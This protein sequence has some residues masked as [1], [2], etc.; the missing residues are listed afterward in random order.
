MAAVDH[1]LKIDGIPGES[2][3]SKHKGEIDIETWEFSEANSGSFALGGGGGAGKVKMDDFTFSKK[4]D[5]AGPKLFQA[6]ASGEHIKGAV[7]T[8]RKAGKD[9]Q[10]YLKIT[11]AD[12]LISN[13]KIIAST[14][15]GEIVPKEVFKLNFSSMK[16]EYKEQKSDGTLAGQV[17]GGWDV[18]KNTAKA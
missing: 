17:V 1:F 8:S 6:C 7:L 16:I 11:F 9:Q 18:Q 14:E 10:E 15:D 3:D 5:K 12:S 2:Q 4:V 13:Y